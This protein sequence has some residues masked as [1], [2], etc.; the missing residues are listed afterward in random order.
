MKLLIAA[1]VF[2]LWLFF[3]PN[4]AVRCGVVGRQSGK[5]LTTQ[6]RFSNEPS[7]AVP[8]P[9]FTVSEVTAFGVI[10]IG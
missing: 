4:H 1:A 10:R 3:P 8:L 6:E 9:H 7:A 5:R 2:L